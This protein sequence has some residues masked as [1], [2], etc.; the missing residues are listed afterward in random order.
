[1]P[2]RIKFIINFHIQQQHMPF[3]IISQ[4]HILGIYNSDKCVCMTSICFW[5]VLCSFIKQWERLKYATK[6][7]AI[8]VVEME[9]YGIICWYVFIYWKYVLFASWYLCI[10]HWER[11]SVL[12]H[13]DNGKRDIYIYVTAIFVSRVFKDG[14]CSWKKRFLGGFCS[15]NQSFFLL[16]VGESRQKFLFFVCYIV[17]C[18]C[19]WLLFF[20]EKLAVANIYIRR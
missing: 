12:L 16:L 13:M 2:Q 11:Y 1:M 4:W 9:R 17:C 5:G 7:L 3:S 6:I 10:T 19:V 8:N 20:K 15:L 14:K 18:V